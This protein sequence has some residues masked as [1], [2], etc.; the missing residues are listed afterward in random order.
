VG[1]VE[2]GWVCMPW[3][4]DGGPFASN[5]AGWRRRHE[6]G[7]PAVNNFGLRLAH[8]ECWSLCAAAVPASCCRQL[9]DGLGLMMGWPSVN[10]LRCDVICCYCCCCC[11]R[12]MRC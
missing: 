3:F 11:V 4:A 10:S 5:H 9:P 6:H 12:C 1:L 7:L 2:P 8:P